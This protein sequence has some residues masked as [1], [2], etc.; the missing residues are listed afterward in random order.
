MVDGG[1]LSNFPIRLIAESVPEIMG[2]T[3]PNGALNLGLLLD[4]QLA[5]PG[6]NPAP[7]PLPVDNLRVVQRISRLMDTMMG[8]Q[9]SEEIRQRAAEICRLPVKGYGTTEFDMPQPKL[10]AL[11]EAGRAAVVAHLQS[12]NLTHMPAVAG[13]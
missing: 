12:R 9:D 11:V 3:D 7:P 5:V 10:T 6:I 13:S 8:A 2:N 1:V 4:E